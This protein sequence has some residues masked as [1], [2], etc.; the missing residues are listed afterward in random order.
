MNSAK[1]L[2][3]G[4]LVRSEGVF[5]FLYSRGGLILRRIHPEWDPRSWSNRE[6]RKWGPLA[7]GD[8]INVSAWEDRDKEGGK[9]A[10]YFPNKGSYAISNYGGARGTSD[11]QDQIILDLTAELPK[12]LE[13]RYD[14]VFNHTTLEHIYEAGHAMRSL[15]GLSRDLVIIVVPF[16]QQLHWDEGSFR[17]YWRFS[18]FAMDELF[19]GCGFRM[20]YCTTNDSPV[21]PV[22]LF[23][24]GARDPERWIAEMQNRG[25]TPLYRGVVDRI[26][27]RSASAFKPPP[28]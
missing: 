4:L 8:V 5:F 26:P 2:L 27:G 25:I 24:V 16:L 11:G 19:R 10:D 18:P 1:R 7:K 22:Y 20:I 21:N 12:E 28:A 17:D 3:R 14:V 6:L 23:C 13:R 15:C 9:Y